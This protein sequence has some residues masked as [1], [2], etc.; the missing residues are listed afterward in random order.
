[1]NERTGQ[2]TNMGNGAAMGFICGALL[3]VGVALL[4]APASGSET[5]RKLGE[6]ARRLRREVP[7]KARGL[8][9]QA[10]STLGA[11]QEGVRQGIHEGRST[12]DQQKTM[13]SAER[14]GA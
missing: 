2:T 4:M 9:N 13:Y 12:Y 5:R 3:G 10:R 7:E 1:M 11:V 6:T 8:A 14:E